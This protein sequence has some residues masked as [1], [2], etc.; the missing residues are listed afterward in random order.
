[1]PIHRIHWTT[2]VAGTQ[3][4]EVLEDSLRWLGGQD[5]RFENEKVKSWHGSKLNTISALIEKKKSCIASLSRVG[6]EALGKITLEL[7][8][9]LDT[10]KQLHLRLCQN[11]LVKG[12]IRLVEKTEKLPVVKGRVKFVVYPNEDL[13]EVVKSEIKKA[14]DMSKNK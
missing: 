11:E 12:K 8:N 10:Q 6:S 3:S 5:A 13:Q 9:R 1:M 4:F 14:I 7:E 2:T